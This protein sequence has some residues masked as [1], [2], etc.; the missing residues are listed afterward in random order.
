MDFLL[1]ALSIVTIPISIALNTLVIVYSVWVLYLALMNLK[2]A[3]DNGKLGPVAYACG[4]P[5]LCVGYVLDFVMNIFVMSLILMELPRETLVTS[6]VQ[7]LIRDEGFR[8]K[9]CRYIAI[10]FLNAFDP[11]GYHVRM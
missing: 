2:G 7:R 10:H 11:R 4:I 8:G 5:I 6:R 1:N 3:R 9:V